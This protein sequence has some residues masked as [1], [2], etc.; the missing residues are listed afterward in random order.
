MNA[1][2]TAAA[3]EHTSQEQA[4]GDPVRPIDLAERRSMREIELTVVIPTKNE[5]QNLPWVLERLPDITDEVIIVDGMSTD[6][7]VDVARQVRPDVRVVMERQPGKGAALRAGFAAAMGRYVVMIDADGSMDPG[8][9]VRYVAMLRRDC[10]FVKGSRFR[11]G[12]GSSDISFV[13]NL[14]NAVLRQTVNAL[15]RVDMTDLCYGFMGFR[16]DKLGLLNLESDG[17]EIETEIIV[18]AIK[19]GLRI[20]EVPSFEA[21]RRHG[22]SNLNAWRDG[23]RVLRTLLSERWTLPSTPLI[24]P[25]TIEALESPAQA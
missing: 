13:R 9:I 3:L 10:D 22:E 23:R 24:E 2:M 7:T 12:G 25:A 15:Y 1:R 19:V 18:R 11:E 16:R 14:G 21:E 20:G 17:F 5:A 6:G 8:E 4:N